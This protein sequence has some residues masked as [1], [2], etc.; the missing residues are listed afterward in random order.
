MPGI[1]TGSMITQ[2]LNIFKAGTSKSDITPFSGGG[3]VGNFGT[4]PPA[5]TIHDD[6][7]ARCLVLDD[8][9]TRLAFVIVDIIGINRDLI[10]E[11]NRIINEETGIPTGNLLISAIYTRSAASLSYRRV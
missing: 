11:A 2:S 5:T 10:D 4:P 7:H 6:L 8:S 9:S 3:I 1:L